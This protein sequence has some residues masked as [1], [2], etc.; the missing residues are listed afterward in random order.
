ML[1]AESLLLAAAAVTI[2]G[3]LAATALRAMMLAWTWSLAALAPAA[4]LARAGFVA[5]SPV[6]AAALVASAVGWRWHRRDL[7]AGGD[8]A[9]LARTR[10]GLADVLAARLLATRLARAGWLGEGTLAVGVDRRGLPVSVPL[11]RASGSHCLLLGATGSGKTVTEAWIACRLVAR[12]LGAVVIDPK[13]DPLL[14]EE[15]GRAAGGRLLEWTPE[16][17]SLYNPYAHGS[18]SEL[19][20]KA[21]AGERFSEP[22]YLRQ[23]Q[24]YLAHAVR[25]MRAAGV[26]VTPAT[27]MAHLDPSALEE[28][29]RRCPQRE[30]QAGEGYL[31]T[32]GE[33]QRRE[34]GGV[35]DRMSILAESDLSHWLEP[36][37]GAPAI[38][39][40]RALRE[41][42]VVYFRLDADRHALLAQMLAAALV[43]DLVTVI[44]AAQR[45]PLRALVVIDEFAAIA[46]PQ[47][48]SLFAR[49]RSAGVSVLLATQELADL[50]V[51]R[52]GLREQV[53]GNIAA[54][55]AHRQN[56]PASA[57]LVAAIAGTR[58]AWLTTHHDGGGAARRR[59]REARLEAAEVAALPTG[60][61][62]VLTPAGEQPPAI[63][64]MHHPRQLRVSASSRA[65]PGASSSS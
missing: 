48:A 34:L 64:R 8:L 53:L 9:A 62:V 65:D 11:G 15:L 10:R 59:G 28:T 46:A 4:L 17:P 60:W 7:A 47:V 26:A 43:S 45:E 29:L 23:A 32:L 22:H 33:R 16:G 39:L 58:P 50:D 13:G 1:A 31:A 12:G 54:L 42:A 25:A 38:E 63:A 20:D 35:R 52:R 6:L 19:A 21:L 49:A 57:E 5:G 36:R 61:A 56:V 2:G 44:A 24:R 51:A 3:I 41:R 27:L 37:A 30:A 55:I 14:R 18:D 40:R